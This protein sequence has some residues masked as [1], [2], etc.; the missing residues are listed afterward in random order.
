MPPKLIKNTLKSVWRSVFEVGQAVGVDIL[1]RHFYSQIPHIKQLRQDKS[2]RSPMSMH[3]VNASDVAQQLEFARQC[4]TADCA[5]KMA[6]LEIHTTAIKENMQDGGYGPAEALFLYCYTR[7]MKPRK[8]IQVGCGVSTSIILRAAAD[9][10]YKPEIVCVEPYPSQ[11]LQSASAAGKIKLIAER[12]Q[13]VN[14]STLTDLQ[15]GDLFFV[16]STHTVKAGSEVNRIILEVLPR[17]A[18]RMSR[19]LSR[20]LLPV[21]LQARLA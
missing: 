18:H 11:F 1:P 7:S 14:L 10:G 2:W 21:R 19:S 13:T 3:G 15:A 16:D 12:A 6:D 4:V 5:P 8:V 20:H 17:V 9:A